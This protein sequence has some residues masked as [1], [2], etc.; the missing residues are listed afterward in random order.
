MT[1]LLLPIGVDDGGNL[2][3]VRAS[4]LMT[5][6]T[7]FWW[8][9]ALE[10]MITKSTRPAPVCWH[11]SCCDGGGAAACCCSP[12]LSC[13]MTINGL[14]A[15]SPTVTLSVL[16][17]VV[18]LGFVLPLLPLPV[19]ALGCGGG[20][21]DCC[22][23]HCAVTFNG[24]RAASLYRKFAGTFCGALVGEFIWGFLAATVSSGILLVLC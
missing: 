23:P 9:L 5:V 17:L 13:T 22:S 3:G 4:V 10:A 14:R 24:L 19:L 18:T 7:G 2:V 8:P 20:G 11:A 21:F 15:A 6:V 1:D 16:F 12:S